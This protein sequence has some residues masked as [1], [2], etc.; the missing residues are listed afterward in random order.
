MLT[1]FDSLP[2]ESPSTMVTQLRTKN[3]CVRND[4]FSNIGQ[5]LFEDHEFIENYRRHR[6]K[7]QDLKNPTLEAYPRQNMEASS[8]IA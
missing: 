1:V 3:M 2:A 5:A 6:D 4:K 7:G 8:S